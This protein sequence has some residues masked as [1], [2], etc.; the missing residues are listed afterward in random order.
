MPEGNIPRRVWAPQEFRRWRSVNLGNKRRA[1]LLEKVI[2]AL[3][4][5]DKG[6][7]K[8]CVRGVT[9]HD[10]KRHAMLHDRRELI[11]FVAD[12]AIM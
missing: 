6:F 1:V 11:G 3:L 4:C 9:N 10:Q 7:G 5:S 12:P 8:L 2:D